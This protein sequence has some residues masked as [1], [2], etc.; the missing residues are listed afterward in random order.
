MSF[1]HPMITCHWLITCHSFI[2][3]IHSSTDHNQRPGPMKNEENFDENRT[4][5][6]RKRRET[7]CQKPASNL[8]RLF[9]RKYTFFPGKWTP[10]DEK[11]RSWQHGNDIEISSILKRILKKIEARFDENEFICYEALLKE[12]NVFQRKSSRQ[13]WE[14]DPDNMKT[15]ANIEEKRS[16][17]SRKTFDIV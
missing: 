5:I 12:I 8:M 16:E 10:D 6:W 11:K 7:G 14:N 2:T 9:C 1:T 17:F 15:R 13:Q 4:E 3:F